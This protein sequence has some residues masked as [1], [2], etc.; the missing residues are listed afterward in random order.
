MVC[1]PTIHA[2]RLAM[3]PVYDN[4][5]RRPGNQPSA[6]RVEHQ[7]QGQDKLQIKMNKSYDSL[8]GRWNR[9]CSDN[10]FSGPVSAVANF[11]ASLYQDGLQY[12]S[13]NAYKSAISS[14]HRWM[15]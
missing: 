1:P 3:P 5:S 6:G 12:S 8:F 13:V 14:V 10:P 15:E 7:L 11:L 4:S 2:G 9:W